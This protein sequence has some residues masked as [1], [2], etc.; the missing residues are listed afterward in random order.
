MDKRLVS[1]LLKTRAAVKRKYQSLKSDIEQSQLQL[2]K[3]F[4][5]ISQPLEQLI[6]AIKTEGIQTKKITTKLGKPEI[7][8]SPQ[9]KVLHSR[10]KSEPFQPQFLDA[11]VIAESAPEEEF[12]EEQNVI[13]EDE[14]SIQE[15]TQL[16]EQMMRPEILNEYLEHYKGLARQ[17]IEEMIR[18]TKDAFDMQYGVRFDIGADKFSIGNKSLE[19]DG[20]DMYIIDG[21]NKIMYKGT[22]GFYELMFKKKPVGYNKKDEENY[23]DIVNRSAANHKNYDP[24]GPISGNVGKKY[25][26]VIR[27][28]MTPKPPRRGTGYLNV[29]N[30]RVEFVPWKNPNTL[31]DRLQ[32]LMASQLAGHTGHNNEIVTIID[33]LKKS[34]IIK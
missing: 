34:K 1:D 30:K 25:L 3:Q 12:A 19:F 23:K 9:P 22:P 28:L 5:P 17:Y 4:K 8:E 21:G 6:S 10:K 2:A 13:S 16:V 14:Q 33:V 32:I 27:P 11:E 18:D 20:E 29:N 24:A 31:V 15:A 26:K 7:K